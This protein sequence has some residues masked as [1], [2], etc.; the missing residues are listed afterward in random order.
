MALKQESIT[1]ED[2]RTR[3]LARRRGEDFRVKAMVNTID[4]RVGQYLSDIEV[5]D[6][7]AR[8]AVKVNIVAAPKK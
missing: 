1:L 4:Y 8:S 3:S 2:H 7:L 5:N 6:M